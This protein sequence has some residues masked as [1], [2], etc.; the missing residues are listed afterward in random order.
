MTL[1]DDIL[2]A[3][4]SDLDIGG[5]LTNLGGAIKNAQRFKLTDEVT[6][7][8]VELIHSRPSTLNA[9]LP[10]CRL[11]YPV[12][13]IETRGGLGHNHSTTEDRPT[14]VR[15]GVLIES[16]DDTGQT[17]VMTVAWAHRIDPD[18]TML[19]TCSPFAIYFD[20]R[21]DDA[22]SNLVNATHTKLLK[23][24]NNDPFLTVMIHG[25]AHRFQPKLSH[26]QLS[27][28]MRNTNPELARY[29]IDS[30]EVEAFHQVERRVQTGISPHATR[31]L[32][33]VMPNLP[34]AEI[35]R[36][37]NDWLSDI[38]GE[39]PFVHCFLAMLNSRNPCLEHN[40][41]DLSR[42]NKSRVK[43]GR[44]PFL[45]HVETRLALSRSQANR[46]RAAGLTREQARQHLCRGHFKIRKTGVYWW[47]PFLR[48]DPRR[49][50]GRNE[51][52]IS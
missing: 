12:I 32:Q 27:E 8:C 39:A 46:A 49:P 21:E 44:A 33:I 37:L 22:V 11:P 51:Y 28:A 31:F 18:R 23:E 42:L 52:A 25:T 47:R 29:A 26:V 10:L 13:W 17:G 35:P 43:R 9:A 41:A 6:R 36:R 45:D 38:A 30:K 4:G 3:R 19:P 16:A 14:P 20:W 7:A 48:G 5:V 24:T 15:Q 34:P 50:V 1:G 2:A 40:K